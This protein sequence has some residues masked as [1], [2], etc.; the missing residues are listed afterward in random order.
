[1]RQF[2]CKYCASVYLSIYLSIYLSNLSI[3]PT[4]YPYIYLF[5]YQS[6]HIFNSIYLS[7]Y[8]F[9]YLSIKGRNLDVL[10]LT[11]PSP[12]NCSISEDKKVYT[13]PLF[14]MHKVH[15]ALFKNINLPHTF[16][17]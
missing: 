7:I 8:L 4:I 12:S 15:I 17:L 1:M 16:K 9:F 13:F 6:I 2:T 3:Y 10:T 14:Y 5:I 11:D